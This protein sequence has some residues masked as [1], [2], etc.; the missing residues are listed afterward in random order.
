MYKV[1]VKCAITRYQQSDTEIW[2]EILTDRH[3]LI[4][5]YWPKNLGICTVTF[6]LPQ[7]WTLKCNQNSSD[8][9]KYL[10][11]KNFVIKGFYWKKFYVYLFNLLFFLQRPSDELMSQSPMVTN[12]TSPPHLSGSDNDAKKVSTKSDNDAKKVS[13]KSDNDAKKVSTKSV[14]KV[15]QRRQKKESACLCLRLTWHKKSG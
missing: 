9:E 14:S 10:L 15:R 1:R 4:W 12:G 5:R 3:S 13:T 8:S 11:H 6:I 7:R 2:T